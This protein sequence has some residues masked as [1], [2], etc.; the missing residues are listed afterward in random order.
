MGKKK[1]RKRNSNAVG[2]TIP[3]VGD[4]HLKRMAVDCRKLTHLDVSFND[5][6]SRNSL[7]VSIHSGFCFTFFQISTRGLA[8]LE[9]NE[10]SGCPNLE[11]LFVFECYL[12]YKEMASVAVGMRKSLRHLVQ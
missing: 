4:E 12:D 8:Y 1:K 10:C 6:C 11:K 2:N 7:I 3:S 5:V 9:P